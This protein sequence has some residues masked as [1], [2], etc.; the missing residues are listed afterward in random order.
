[1]LKRIMDFNYDIEN[2]H[3]LDMIQENCV[4]CM[5]ASN[6]INE[7]IC[8]CKNIH[9]HKDCL[10]QWISVKQKL[11]CEIC[12]RRYRKKLITEYKIHRDS[13]ANSKTN[14]LKILVIILLMAYVFMLTSSYVFRSNKHLGLINI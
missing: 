10:F 13:L 3:E 12:K 7:R 11:S 8:K 2:Q 9:Y 14:T 6:L 1:M 4:I 5:E